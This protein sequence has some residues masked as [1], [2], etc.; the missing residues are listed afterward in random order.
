MSL[1]DL[2]LNSETWKDL[3]QRY[4]EQ[5]V[6]LE[7]EL[8]Q[9]ESDRDRGRITYNGKEVGPEFSDG[10]VSIYS[11][12]HGSV[13]RDGNTTIF[14]GGGTVNMVSNGSSV[15]ISSSRSAYS[16][17]EELRS[18]EQD[19]N[20]AKQKYQE[21]LKA[22]RKGREKETRNFNRGVDGLQEIDRLKKELKTLSTQDIGKQ[23]AREKVEQILRNNPRAFQQMDVLAN[24]LKKNGIILEADLK[25]GAY[26]RRA[27]DKER[28]NLG[29]VPWTKDEQGLNRI[30]G[31]K[32]QWNQNKKINLSMEKDKKGPYIKLESKDKGVT[33]RAYLDGEAKPFKEL[34]NQWEMEGKTFQKDRDRGI[35]KDRG[36]ER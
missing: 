5:K 22:E 34:K 15:R 21:A 35:D 27:D 17:R 1:N 25:G 19:L 36:M 9:V 4:E 24:D 20:V 10:D 23:E 2:N 16:I 13:I 7:K 30:D 11:D 28:M 3:I 14:H 32:I 18:T 6:K 26:V 8:E 33:A 31:D 29:Y 12:G